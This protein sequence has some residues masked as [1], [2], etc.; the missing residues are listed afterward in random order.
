MLE[1]ETMKVLVVCSGNAKNF[2]FKTHKAFVYEQIEALKKYFDVDYTTFFIQEKGI[3]GYLKYVGFLRKTVSKSH[4]DLLHSHYGL[5]GLVSVMQ[6]SVPVVLT[7]HGSDINKK[8]HR[9][10]SSVAR[11]FS[12]FTIF[13]SERMTKNFRLNNKD[14][15]IPCGIELENFRQMDKKEARIRLGLKQD[16]KYVL[17]ASSFCV[18]EKN[19]PLA[20][21]SIQ[22]TNLDLELIELKGK[23]REE[24]NLLLNAVDLLLLTSYSEGSP[25]IIKEAMACDCPIVSTDVGDVREVIG[26]T[27][28]CYLT[29]FD[30]E[31]VAAKIKQAF[32]FGQRTNG[33]KKIEY[34][35]NKNIAGEIF[36]IYQHAILKNG[37]CDIKY[38]HTPQEN[39]PLAS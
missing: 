5:S 3:K 28:G 26:S 4:Y 19:Y 2:N 9:L 11:K 10:L 23:M 27:E 35:D 17:F 18:E 22:A 8:K 25:Q 24:V 15:I 33:R 20:K 36:K 34:L 13:V 14:F 16:E 31:D 38:E 39:L 7:L 30:P 12:N 29:T 6:R 37:L 1:T 32:D 21:K